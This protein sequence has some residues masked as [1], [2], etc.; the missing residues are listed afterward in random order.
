MNK[1]IYK[2]ISKLI[3][4]YYPYL[5]FFILSL[6]LHLI[7]G[8]FADDVTFSNVL[9]K[10]SLLGY[11]KYRYIIWDSR[12]IQDATLVIF[13]NI[14]R[15]IWKILDSII[16]TLGVYYTIK[17]VN[18]ENNK[19]IIIFGIL[20]FLMYPFYE[21]GS[22]GWIATTLTYV[23]SFSLGMISFIPLINEYYNEK[24]MPLTYVIS[25]L[26]LLYAV[27][28]EQSCALIFGFSLL[29]LI[30]SIIKKEKI[31]K[32]GMLILLISSLS[33]LNIFTC[34]GTRSR[35]LL[36]LNSKYPVYASFGLL[37]KIYL[38]IIPTIGILL[39]DKLIF[40]IFYI[41]L[42][43][44]SSLKTKK[45]YLKYIFYF[46]ILF[47][48]FIMIYKILFD[49]PVVQLINIY[50][51]LNSMILF[52]YKGVPTTISL[53]LILTLFISLYL[54]GS[55]CF[56]LLETYEKKIFPLILFGAGFISRFIMGFS[57]EVFSSGERTAFYFY[58][59]LIMLILM[60]IKKLY[61]ENIINKQVEDSI[62][63]VFLIL[64]T[65]EYIYTFLLI[66]V[67]F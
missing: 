45:K 59:I 29:Y 3:K 25:I 18:K 43:I 17:L 55:S 57:P 37:E 24:T 41:I 48:S 5:I 39:T 4:I 36:Q 53:P 7:T 38:G 66:F 52:D 49:I 8:F 65:I 14:D 40:P 64:A 15:I 13:S 61:D 26:A 60:L 22:A 10:W 9:S 54:I 35:F 1:T 21:M 33:L 27:N 2:K 19:Q 20:L 62:T 47:I 31:N 58:M 11:L 63:I 51:L 34:P 50:P 16:Y 30:N 6:F 67:R 32:Y 44:S 56:M 46:N 12:M 28:Q 23:W 42:S